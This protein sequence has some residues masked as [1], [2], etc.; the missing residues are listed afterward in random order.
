MIIKNK[1]NVV[2]PFVNMIP[3][4]YLLDANNDNYSLMVLEKSKTPEISPW[5]ITT[6]QRGG[7]VTTLHVCK[8]RFKMI[9]TTKILE[10]C[11]EAADNDNIKCMIYKDTTSFTYMYMDHDEELLNFYSILNRIFML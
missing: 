2:D 1:N 11:F 6:I 5:D 8:P 7:I 4:E 9:Q 3:L 10:F